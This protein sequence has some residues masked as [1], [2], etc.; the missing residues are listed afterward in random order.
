MTA[1][2][3]DGGPGL[4][5]AGT[6][7][8]TGAGMTWAYLFQGLVVNKAGS[9]FR[10]LELTLLDLLAK[11]PIREWES[12]TGSRCMVM[13]VELLLVREVLPALSGFSKSY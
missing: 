9:I 10:H 11:L 1:E 12:A 2:T 4:S 5:V 8:S 13:T 7:R 6:E 3:I